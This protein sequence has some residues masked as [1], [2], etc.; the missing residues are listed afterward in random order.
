MRSPEYFDHSHEIGDAFVEL[1]H[2]RAKETLER[3]RVDLEDFEDFYPENKLA[4]DKEYV[5]ARKQM[6][7]IPSPSFIREDVERL[8]KAKKM[9]EIMEAMIVDPKVIRS[10]YEF[11]GQDGKNICEVN[12]MGTSEL[13]DL[14]N[15]VDAVWEMKHYTEG[16]S[17]LA[18]GVDITFSSDF[19]EKLQHIKGE[20]DQ[21]E[22]GKVEYF[23]PKWGDIKGELKRVPKVVIGSDARHLSEI[24]PMWSRLEERRSEMATHPMQKLILEEILLQLPVY[25]KY[26]RKIGQEDIAEKIRITKLKFDK[27]YDQIRQKLPGYYDFIEEDQVFLNLKQYLKQFDDL[28]SKVATG[29][30]RRDINQKH[31]VK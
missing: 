4:A 15:G 9:S 25:E 26:A 5:E 1:A 19:K 28:E 7:E 12:A 24:A 23:M 6:M 11:E 10:W 29:K 8:E 30:L 20:L 16:L 3:N 22:M 14:A 31:G 13:D 17:H 21:G 27:L 2:R 18:L